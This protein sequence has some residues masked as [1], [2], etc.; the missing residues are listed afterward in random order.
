MKEEELRLETLKLA[1][2]YGSVQNIKDPVALADTYFKWVKS[3]DKQ[4]APQRK[5]VSKAD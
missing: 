1:V 2:S 4:N 3:G 5:P